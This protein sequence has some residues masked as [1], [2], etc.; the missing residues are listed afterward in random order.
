ML[1]HAVR[2]V[3]LNR[4]LQPLQQW[5]IRLA[6]QLQGFTQIPT[7]HIKLITDRAFD[8]IPF[9]LNGQVPFQRSHIQE[10]NIVI[11]VL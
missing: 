10:T 8:N 5:W 11:A 6:K 1:C 4:G 2:F 7:I 3:I 9:I